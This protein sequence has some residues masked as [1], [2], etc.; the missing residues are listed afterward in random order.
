MG[1]KT[2]NE[3]APADERHGTARGH[4]RHRGHH[5]HHEE[6]GPPW[7]RHA[8]AGG[9]FGPSWAKG[10]R[11]RRGDVRT[12]LLALLE[13][14]PMHGY[15]VIREIEQRSGGAWRPSPGSIYPTLQM[16]EE[17]GLLT[18]EGVDGKRTYAITDAGRGELAERRQRAGG[19]A[20]WEG[21][22]FD[23]G[24]SGLREAAFQLGGAAMQVAQAGSSEQIARAAEVL[25]EARKKLYAI[26][27]EG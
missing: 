4:G 16:L 27:A 17:E 5:H 8:R 10:R 6:G 22:G 23:E 12:G 20:P 18:S 21:R 7:M 14:R 3:E 9:W 26:L 13:E 24:F 11:T 19:A 2:W 1:E 25:G 15:D